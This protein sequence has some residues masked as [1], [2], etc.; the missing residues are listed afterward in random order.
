MERIRDKALLLAGGLTAG[1]LL[2]MGVLELLAIFAGITL[3]CLF[4]YSENK[5]WLYVGYG[6]CLVIMILVPQFLL[7]LPMLIY[8][9]VYQ[10][11]WRMVLGAGASAGIAGYEAYISHGMNCISGVELKD[12]TV[13]AWAVFSCSVGWHSSFPWM[14]DE[15]VSTVKAGI[16]GTARQQPRDGALAEREK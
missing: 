4:E 15:N 10:R 14:E 7:I 13:C 1:F 12:R 6:V 16:F 3:T 11:C 5:Y 2:G 8:D 9:M